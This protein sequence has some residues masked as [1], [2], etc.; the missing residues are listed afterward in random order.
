MVGV[1]NDS[2]SNL[3][4]AS[5]LQMELSPELSKLPSES[6]PNEAVNGAAATAAS[7]ASQSTVFH[8]A[9][10]QQFQSA[11][12]SI[13]TD[14]ASEDGNGA[15]G[16]VFFPSNNLGPET[17]EEKGIE[18]ICCQSNQNT[19]LLIYASSQATMELPQ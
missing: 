9:T 4:V 7:A 8:S 6:G 3:S 16:E 10:S 2:L 15:G 18:R 17:V 5:S 12:T 11:L 14:L 1:D 19:H 13:R